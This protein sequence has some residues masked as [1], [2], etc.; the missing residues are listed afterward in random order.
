M[1]ET[2]INPRKP[3]TDGTFPVFLPEK[4]FANTRAIVPYRDGEVGRIPNSTVAEGISSGMLRDVARF[5][6]VVATGVPHHVTQRGNARAFVLN[7]D[8]DREVYLDLLREYAALHEVTVLGPTGTR[9]M[10]RADTFGRDGITRVHWI[11]RICGRR[12]VMRN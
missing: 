10:G 3:G 12:C 9:G 2:I 11:G 4:K 5:A 8:T 7:S 1:V 6:R